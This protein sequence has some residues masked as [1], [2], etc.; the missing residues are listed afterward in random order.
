MSYVLNTSHKRIQMSLKRG[1][2]VSVSNAPAFKKRK[3]GY[4]KKY[5]VYSRIRTPELHQLDSYQAPFSATAA[6]ANVFHLSGIAEGDT[7]ANRQGAKCWPTDL[8][9]K[10]S[11]SQASGSPPVNVRMICFMDKACNGTL[12]NI[13]SA[14][15]QNPTIYSTSYRPG[16]SDRFVIL[17]DYL[18]TNINSAI[19]TTM[20]L[21]K[22]FSLKTKAPIGFIGSTSA[23]ASASTNHY[24]FLILTDATIPNNTGGLGV[25]ASGI[26]LY[27][28][29]RFQE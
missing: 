11:V 15:L 27:W 29:L 20:E 3:A 21:R 28:S 5:P 23:I 26:Q 12:T 8:E 1:L 22:K 13:E 9:V 14:L 18:S 19:G 4:K 17:G 7:F 25:L 16:Y 6:T 2:S 24:F 10:A